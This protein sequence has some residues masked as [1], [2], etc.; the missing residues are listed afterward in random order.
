MPKSTA[1]PNFDPTAT[2]AMPNVDVDA[3]MAAQRRNVD[4]TYHTRSR[5]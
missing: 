2:F 5:C 4:Y 1:T 3:L